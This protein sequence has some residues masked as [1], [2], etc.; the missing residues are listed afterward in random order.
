MRSV[1]A[2]ERSGRCVRTELVTAL[3]CAV[4]GAVVSALVGDGDGPRDSA[5]ATLIDVIDVLAPIDEHVA[6]F[7]P[8]HAS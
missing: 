8:M 1:E 2:V 5:R 6:R 3:V 7:E 4:D